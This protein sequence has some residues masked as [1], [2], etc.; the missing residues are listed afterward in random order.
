MQLAAGLGRSQDPG[1]HPSCPQ[2]RSFIRRLTRRSGNGGI[3]GALGPDCPLRVRLLSACE[4]VH[5]APGAFNFFTQQPRLSTEAGRDPASARG[6]A[7]CTVQHTA[8]SA[9]AAEASC[10]VAQ[11]TAR[12]P[13]RTGGVNTLSLRLRVLVATSPRRGGARRPAAA[14]AVS[15]VAP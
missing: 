4:L 13:A 15:Y 9:T 10:C 2:F 7:A 3:N 8:R 12:G 14:W 6:G 11:R 1:A 5:T